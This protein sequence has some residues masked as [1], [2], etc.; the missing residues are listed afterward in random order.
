MSTLKVTTLSTPDGSYSVDISDIATSSTINLAGPNTAVQFN[1]AGALGGE[2]E[3]SYDKT[4][5]TLSVANLSVSGSMNGTA[6]NSLNAATANLANIANVA[7]GLDATLAN[8][9]ITGG[10]SG[11]VLKTNGSGVLSWTTVDT[12]K[13]TSGSSNILV[14]GSNAN[15]TATTLNVSG[16]TVIAGNLTVNGT[17]TTVNS[18]TLSTNDKNIVLANNATTR[19]Q[20]D[21]AGITINGASATMLY[22]NAANTINFSHTLGANITGSAGTVTNGTQANITALGNLSSLRVL[23]VTDLGSVSNVSITGGTT[24]QYLKTN[25]SGA[26]S[27]GTVGAVTSVGLTAGAGMSVSGGPIT[28]SGSITVVNTG[29]LSVNAG[30]GIALSSATGNPV[31]SA[32]LAAGSGITVTQPATAGQAV[33]VGANV[34]SLV[35]GNGVQVTNASGAWTVKANVAS[36][37]GANG[38]TVTSNATS[39]VYTI[40]SPVVGNLSAYDDIIGGTNVTVT[41]AAGNITIATASAGEVLNMNYATEKVTSGG[42]ASGVYNFDVNTSS[43]VYNSTAATGNVTLNLRANSSATLASIV[44]SGSSVTVTYLMTTGSTGYIVDTVKVDGVAKTINWAGGSIPVAT[45]LVLMSYTFTV[46]NIGG[47]YT[48][49]GSA[50]RFG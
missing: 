8:V 34:A 19:A 33:T 16:D 1:D 43:V 21:G 13:I 35:A 40:S 50:T 14:D 18:T 47:T 12:D 44:P 11:Q 24:G 6:I 39:G 17:T 5:N 48:V 20:A 10:T 49:L 38:T 45:T 42:V 46:I 23:G 29:V 32:N 26:L 3:F 30:N 15:I 2:A 22:N 25:G 37:V 31:I 27:W 41:K 36:V 7:H 4:T 9:S 28:S